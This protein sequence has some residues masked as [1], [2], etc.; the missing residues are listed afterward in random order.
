MTLPHTSPPGGV[1]PLTEVRNA[2][3]EFCKAGGRRPNG[4]R[5]VTGNQNGTR[6]D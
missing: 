2:V 4:I 3:E 6:L 5:W 1:L